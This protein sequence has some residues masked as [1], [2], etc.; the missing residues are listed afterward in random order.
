MALS[1]EQ[2]EDW[3][4]RPS[5]FFLEWT[6]TV[7][8]EALDGA[9]QFRGKC[10]YEIYAQGSYANETNV[11]PTG[12]VDLVVQ[13]QLP[14]EEEITTLDRAEEE[15]FWEK[16]G[17]ATYRWPQFRADV[18]DRLRESFFVH[19]GNKCMDIRHFDSPMRLPADI[20]PAI[21]YRDYEAFP[22]R[23]VEIYEEGIFFRDR[24]GHPIINYPKQHLQN[25][26]RKD[27][28]VDRGFKPV[29][30]VFKNALR[31]LERFDRAEAPSYFVECLVYNI[32]NSA[33]EGPIHVT[34]P[35]CVRWLHDHR[36]EFGDFMCQNEIVPLFGDGWR[37][38]QGYRLVDA[39]R[40]QLA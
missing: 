25:G 28:T 3:S 31:N 10:D 27:A 34:Y 9:S 33:F 14:F 20:V 35:Q 24:A 18:L 30:R 7:L 26:R 17:D 8:V 11:D 16:Y 13:M 37:T 4:R 39:L 6:R 40:T 38:E 12:D 19:V 23:D 15:R 32:G 5:S 21:E 1:R 2:I 22:A 29:V 36:D